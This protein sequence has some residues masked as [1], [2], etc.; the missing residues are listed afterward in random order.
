MIMDFRAWGTPVNDDEYELSTD[1]K[2]RCGN[3]Q[4]YLSQEDRYCRCC[5]TQRGKG[6]FQPYLNSMQCIYGPPPVP[7]NHICRSCGYR[8]ETMAM[9]DRQKYCP[10]CGGQADMYEGSLDTETVFPKTSNATI[11]LYVKSADWKQEFRENE[12]QIGRLT[13]NHLVLSHKNVSRRHAKLRFTGG[14]WYLIDLQSVNGTY[15]NG[16]KLIPNKTYLVSEGDRISFGAEQVEVWDIGG[17]TV[18]L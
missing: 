3:C 12:I 6:A 18:I 5:G 10:Q 9:I 13:D 15:L 14:S 17:N 4:E 16:Q 7:R 8:W 11:A 1:Y 2:N